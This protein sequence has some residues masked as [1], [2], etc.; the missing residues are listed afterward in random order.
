MAN[1]AA[2]RTTQEANLA[3]RERRKVV[4]QHKALLGLAL[5]AFQTL[6]VIAGAQSGSD[7]GLGFTAGKDGR[8][9]STRQHADFG[10]NRANLIEGAAV[11]TAAVLG[12]FFAENQLTQHVE[13]LAGL[14]A[15]FRLVLGNLGL[16]AVLER[17]D[18]R[19]AVDL[20]Q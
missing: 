17:L 6:H 13:I 8:T 14:G 3:D 12:D 19:V 1:F 10:P 7:Q 15:G 9:V 5:E 20:S 16:D 4:V 18:L 2:S 11:G